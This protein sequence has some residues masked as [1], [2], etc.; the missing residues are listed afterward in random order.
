MMICFVPVWRASMRRDNKKA[1]C[2]LVPYTKSHDT[3][4]SCSGFSSRATSEKPTMPR[5]S[6]GNCD[7]IN[8]CSA[9]ATFLAARKLSR[10]GID[11]DST[12]IKNSDELEYLSVTS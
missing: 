10:I 8:E 6:R 7:E 4:G 11:N 5:K 2:M 1:C 3:S 12:R 9:I